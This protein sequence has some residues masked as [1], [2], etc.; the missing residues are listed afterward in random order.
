RDGTDR[1]TDFELGLDQ[2]AIAGVSRLGQITF[3]DVAA[4]ARLVANGTT[5]IVEGLTAAE[6][7]DADNFLF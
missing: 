7:R 1:I 2:I 6:M 3:S 4:G 5:I